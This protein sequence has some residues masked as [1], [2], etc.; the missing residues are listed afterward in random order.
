[1]THTNRK[2]Q[3]GRPGHWDWNRPFQ[4]FLLKKTISFVHAVWDLTDLAWQ[5]WLKFKFSW[6]REWPP[7]AGQFWQMG[8]AHGTVKCLNWHLSVISKEKQN[9]I[10]SVLNLIWILVL[11]LQMSRTKK[12]ST[13]IGPAPSLNSLI[14]LWITSPLPTTIRRRCFQVEDNST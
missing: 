1:M 7:V 12:P 2:H 5:F 14:F 13:S 3:T 9:N 8:S 11:F 6:G 4:E 10:L